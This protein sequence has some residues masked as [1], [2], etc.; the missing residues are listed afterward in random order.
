[1]K[2]ALTFI[3][4][5]VFMQAAYAVNNVVVKD[6]AALE[7][8][9][10]SFEEADQWSTEK[11]LGITVVVPPSYTFEEQEKKPFSWAAYFK[12]EDSRAT[13]TSLIHA[14]GLR[15]PLSHTEEKHGHSL[16]LSVLTGE[17]GGT[18]LEFG[19]NQ[20]SG[21]APMLIHLPVQA[22]IE[23][24]AQKK[25]AAPGTCGKPHQPHSTKSAPS[26]TQSNRAPQ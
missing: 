13:G 23:H 12:P 15:L 4:L 3:L 10:F 14:E 25:K 18:Y 1:M 2:S 20:G 24:L 5:I 6:I 19:F 11:S 22:V 16:R 26:G 7:R 9:G 17:A 21:H 8:N